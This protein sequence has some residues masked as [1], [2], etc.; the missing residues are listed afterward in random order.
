MSEQPRGHSAGQIIVEAGLLDPASL[1]A[2]FDFTRD[3]LLSASESYQ[4]ALNS[5]KRIEM[6]TELKTYLYE[7]THY[8]QYTTTPYGLFLQYCRTLQSRMTIEIVRACLDAGLGFR[9]PLLDNVPAATGDTSAKINRALAV[10]LNV[11]SLV[12][13]LNADTEGRL[14]VLERF[15]A[16]QERVHAGQV[17]RRPPLLGIQEA[18]FRIQETL[19][20]M[21]EQNNADAHAE[22]NP[23]PMEITG[24]DR[25]A[26]RQEATGFPSS[27]ELSDLR[28]QDGLDLLG[29][30]FS[31]DTVI[32]SAATA[33]EFWG[34]GSTMV[35]L[36]LGRMKVSIQNCEF[37]GTLSLTG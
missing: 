2:R 32:E 14:A 27:A 21:L 31:V 4:V 8:V 16:D 37:T 9:M 6:P 24:F 3:A 25:E 17:P 19:A 10:W 30:P 29:N 35:V 12:T 18:F 7:L 34:R 15:L 33:A 20:D 13:M 5:G 36:L 23:I 11:E 22:G 28:T 1:F 26:L